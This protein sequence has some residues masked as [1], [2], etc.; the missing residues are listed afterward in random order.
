MKA[1]RHPAHHI[2]I[3]HDR[4]LQVLGAALREVLIGLLQVEQAPQPKPIRLHE[5][6]K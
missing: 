4:P 5:L 3:R 6:E 2:E 1:I